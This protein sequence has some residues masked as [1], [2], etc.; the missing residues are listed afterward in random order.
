MKHR[1]YSKQLSTE[2]AAASRRRFHLRVGNSKAEQNKGSTRVTPA[3]ELSPSQSGRS[4]LFCAVQLG[5]SL[6]AAVTGDLSRA[7]I[8]AIDRVLSI[9]SFI[10]YSIIFVHLLYQILGFSH[11][12]TCPTSQYS[13]QKPFIVRVNT[14]P[15]PVWLDAKRRGF[16]KGQRTP[17]KGGASIPRSVVN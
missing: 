9:K 13:I 10:I 17:T 15:K 12:A 11:V 7:G 2:D 6:T 4:S 14:F 8:A 5:S 1:G 3:Q 16:W